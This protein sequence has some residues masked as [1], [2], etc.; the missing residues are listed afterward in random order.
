MFVS[1]LRDTNLRV[2]DVVSKTSVR[3]Q[4]ET[5]IFDVEKMGKAPVDKVDN[6]LLHTSVKHGKR[7]YG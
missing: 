3:F 7:T 4:A 6:A 2:A 5:R 1:R